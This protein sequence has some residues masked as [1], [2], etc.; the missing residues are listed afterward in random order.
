MKRM[1]AMSV[2]PAFAIRSTNFVCT[3][4]PFADVYTVGKYKNCYEDL[5][6]ECVHIPRV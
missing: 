3:G 2:A 5:G 1:L 6:Y 4:G